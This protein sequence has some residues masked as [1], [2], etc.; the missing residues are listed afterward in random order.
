MSVRRVYVVGKAVDRQKQAYF[1]L[2]DINPRIDIAID[3]QSL[4]SCFLK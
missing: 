4:Y 1:D 2:V 3:N